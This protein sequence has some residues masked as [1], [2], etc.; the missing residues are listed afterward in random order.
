MLGKKHRSK[1]HMSTKR[2][3]L[4]NRSLLRVV[5]TIAL[6]PMWLL[7]LPVRRDRVFRHHSWTLHGIGCVTFRRRAYVIYGVCWLLF[8]WMVYYVVS[9]LLALPCSTK[10][11]R[12]PWGR[13]FVVKQKV[14]NKTLPSTK[15]CAPLP[16]CFT[17]IWSKRQRHYRPP[18]TLINSESWSPLFAKCW[19]L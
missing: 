9:E 3:T 15:R 11:S 4:I 19:H 17:L 12:P 2:F 8:L 13:E 10:I 5:K 6:L 14:C 7:V 16:V 18:L 1:T